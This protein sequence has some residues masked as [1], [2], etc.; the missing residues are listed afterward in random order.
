MIFANKKCFYTIWDIFAETDH[1]SERWAQQGEWE[2]KKLICGENVIHCFHQTKKTGAIK[3]CLKVA[4]L[5][6][7]LEYK[8]FLPSFEVH[9]QKYFK[10]RTRHWSEYDKII[11]SR[12]AFTALGAIQII[13]DTFGALFRP[14]PPHVT[15]FSKWMFL[16]PKD[17]ELLNEWERKCLLKPYLAFKQKFS[18]W[19]FQRVS[20]I[21]WVDP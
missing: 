11:K 20:R 18:W 9:F 1:I 5:K 3:N 19:A 13:R 8:K 10:Q 6:F 14:L 15:F 4:E 7:F 17:F 16:R 21:I 12:K 2:L